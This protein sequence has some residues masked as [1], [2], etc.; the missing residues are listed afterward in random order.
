MNSESYSF[1]Q[2]CNVLYSKVP[3]EQHFQKLRRCVQCKFEKYLTFLNLQTKIVL[4]TFH[5]VLG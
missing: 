2:H 5:A 1:Q 3:E 4:Y